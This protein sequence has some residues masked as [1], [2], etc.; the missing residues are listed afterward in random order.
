M[1]T[2]LAVKGGAGQGKTNSVRAFANLVL[3]TFPNLV[4]VHPV[5]AVV[6]ATGD[7]RLVVEINGVRLGVESQGDPNTGLATRLLDL[8]TNL[9]CTVIIC[10][11]RTRGDTEQAIVQLAINH[12]FQNIWTAPYW[13]RDRMLHP[14]VNEVKGRHILDLLQTLGRI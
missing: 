10:T 8:V 12:A 13:I 4:P 14:V 9:R 2:I 11:C 1:N 5:P 3:F 7:F 6:P